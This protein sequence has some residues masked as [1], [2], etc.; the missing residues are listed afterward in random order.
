MGFLGRH[1]IKA[2]DLL[3]RA[4]ENNFSVSKFHQFCDNQANTVV[5]I[6]T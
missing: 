3:Y 1:N 2:I 6:R 5:I 4:T